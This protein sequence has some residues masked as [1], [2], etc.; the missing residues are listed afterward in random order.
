M[1]SRYAAF[2]TGDADHLRRTDARPEGE[3]ALP[4]VQWLNLIVRSTRKGGAG[5]AVGEVVFVAA[6]R[7][8]PL[9]P[10]R[11]L[12]ERSRFERRG[13]RWLYVGGDALPDF[14]PRRAEPCWCG[15]GIKFHKCHG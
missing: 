6:F 8:A 11:Q 15:S 1:R 7:D 9:A 12:H 3:G 14:R 5:D 10:V 13:G 2:A 4:S